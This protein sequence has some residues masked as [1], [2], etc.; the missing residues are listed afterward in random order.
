MQETFYAEAKSTFKN[1]S[2]FHEQQ[3]AYIVPNATSFI[4]AQTLLSNLLQDRTAL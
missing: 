3:S 4:C 2:T 1:I